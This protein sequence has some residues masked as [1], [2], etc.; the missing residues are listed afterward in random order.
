MR[1]S[2]VTR[3]LQDVRFALRVLRKSP[4]FSASVI[5]ALGIGA[6]TALFS[7]VNSVQLNPLP[8]LHSNQLVALYENKPGQAAPVSYPNFLDWQRA[9]Q[10]FSSMA[11][12]RHERSPRRGSG[13][14]CLRRWYP[15]GRPA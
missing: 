7:L 9:A 2:F 12:Y 8:Y 3:M 13:R 1:G 14:R 10:S 15:D 11:I 4:A 5:V 6:N